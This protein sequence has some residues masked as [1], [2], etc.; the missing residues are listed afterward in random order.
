[1]HGLMREGRPSLPSTLP[2]IRLTKI[3][4]LMPSVMNQRSSVQI[5]VPL[6]W[7]CL[8]FQAGGEKGKIIKQIS[9]PLV[10]FCLHFQAGGEKGKIIK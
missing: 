7:F 5:S 4:H 6:V 3:T 10:W 1:M 9:V 8:H 2:G